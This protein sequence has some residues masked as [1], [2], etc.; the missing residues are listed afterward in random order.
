MAVASD[1]RRARSRT[2]NGERVRSYL[3]AHR[4]RVLAGPRFA[5]LEGGPFTAADD[6]AGN[7]VAVINA[8]TRD[9]LFGGQPAVGQTVE[10][11]GERYRVVGV[12]ARRPVPAH[13]ALL[14]R[15]GAAHGPALGHVAPEL[16]G[17][18]IGHPASAQRGRHP[19]DPGRVR[20]AAAIARPLGHELQD[21][22]A[23]ARRRLL[24]AVSDDAALRP[25]RRWA[26]LGALLVLGFFWRCPRSTW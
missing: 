1:R 26:V 9:R 21:A 17:D 14:R 19:R 3:Q 5:F 18:K 6:D 16:L 11:D 24:E 10:L 15:L 13:R 4:R 22:R 20:V 25:R 7:H 8:A 12:V 23:P 2:S